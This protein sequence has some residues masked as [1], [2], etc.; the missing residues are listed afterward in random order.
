MEDD[1]SNE[2][3]ITRKQ[4]FLPKKTPMLPKDT[5]KGKVA[6]VTGGGTGLGAGIATVLSRL[7]AKVAIV[8]R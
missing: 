8:S 6:F 1:E 5:F 4:F 7:G 3:W 2:A